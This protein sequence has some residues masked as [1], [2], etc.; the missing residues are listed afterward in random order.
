M[1]VL[2]A[3]D[4][5]PLQRRKVGA[6]PSDS[7]RRLW[8]PGDARTTIEHLLRYTFGYCEGAKLSS[9]YP[10]VPGGAAVT[11]MDC[12]V[13]RR[14]RELSYDNPKCSKYSENKKKCKKKWEK[15]GCQWAKSPPGEADRC[16]DYKKMYQAC[17]EIP[18][19]EAGLPEVGR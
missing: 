6:R 3:S 2:V 14:S 8:L 5:L 12:N 13:G 9:T 11:Y 1:R 17:L 10:V 16:T 19:R 7:R 15:H 18:V 4:V